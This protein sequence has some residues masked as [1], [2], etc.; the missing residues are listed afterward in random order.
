MA[1]GNGRN[2]PLNALR[3]F[4]AAAR[5]LSFKKAARE[6][7][8]TPGAVSH[9]VKVLEEF[10]GAALFR[11]LTRALELTSEA[12]AMLP[13]V[14]EGLDNLAEAIERVRA[15]ENTLALTVI[16]PPNF[17]AR[18]LIPR[19]SRFTNAHPSLELHIASRPTMIDGRETGAVVAPVADAREDA[20]VL[21]VRFGNGR[22]PGQQVDEVFSARYVPVCSPKLLEGEHP[23]RVPA[24]LRFHT[25]IHDDTVVEDGARPSW[26]D[27]LESVG[28]NGID[29]SR[30]PH[31][32]DASLAFEAAVEGMGVTLAMKPLLRS[33]IEG[34]RLV[35][36][37]DISAPASYSYYLVCPEASADNPAVRVFRDWLLLEAAPEAAGDD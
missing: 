2:A 36:P 31:F 13:K 29:V 9:Q 16:A 24:D 5:H 10:L 18:W 19:L 1:K 32:S 12:H 22:Y 20:P 6:L 4:E 37:F 17:A 15:R 33:E 35:V 8:V 25:L 3:A 7:H 30:G 23:L 28:V 21:M 34:G 11:R 14:R 27:W 26:S